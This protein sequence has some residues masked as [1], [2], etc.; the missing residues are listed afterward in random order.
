[1]DWVLPTDEILARVEKLVED[2]RKASALKAAAVIT[3]TAE[4]VPTVK[5]HDDFVSRLIKF[6]LPFKRYS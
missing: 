6:V 5:A 4:P 2:E 3:D 1:M